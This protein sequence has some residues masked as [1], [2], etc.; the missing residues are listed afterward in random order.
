MG[1]QKS[2]T[3]SENTNSVIF[4][5]I[6]HISPCNFVKCNKNVNIFWE[7]PVNFPL[8]VLSPWVGW[9]GSAVLVKVL[10]HVFN[11]ISNGVH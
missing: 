2:S 1:G 5:F 7:N 3:F 10:K 8:K 6:C 11:A 4:M 9:V